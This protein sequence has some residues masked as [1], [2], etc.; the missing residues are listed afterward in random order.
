MMMSYRPSIQNVSIAGS[1]EKEGLYEFAVKLADGTQCRVFYHRFP[2]WR[3][4]NVNR[5]QKTPCPVCR[6]DYICNCMEDFKEDFHSQLVDG[7]W[8]D[9]LLA[10]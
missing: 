8:I 10:K 2:E 3:L 5:L 1:N 7:Q 9:K 4:T 6:K